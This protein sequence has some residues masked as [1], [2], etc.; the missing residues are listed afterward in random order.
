M[1]GARSDG[2]DGRESRPDSLPTVR[3]CR[4]F[5]VADEGRHRPLPLSRGPSP[6][7]LLPLAAV[8]VVTQWRAAVSWAARLQ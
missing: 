5:S 6:M 2:G 8:I 4:A 1:H 7:L 3:R